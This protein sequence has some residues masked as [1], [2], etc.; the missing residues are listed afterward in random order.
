MDLLQNPFH[1]LNASPRDNRRRIMELADERSLLL[2]SSECMEARSELTN[3]RKR[4]SAEVAWLPGIGPKRVGEVL[5]LLESS[6]ADLLAVDNLSSIARANLLA[7]GL[8]RLSDHN[9]DDVAE[10]ILEISW[11]FEDLDADELSVIINEERVV[12]GFPEVSDLSAVEAEIQERRRHYRQ[13]IKSAL[14]NLSPKELVE[15]VTVAVESATDYGEEHGP[16]LIADLVDSYEVEAQ[17]FLDKEEGNIKALVEKLRAAVDAE[18]SDSTLAPMVNQLIQVVKNWDTVAQPIQVSAKSRGLDHDASHRVAGLVRGL[19][20]HMFNEHGKLDF[21]Q[22]LT[23]MLQEVFAEVGEVAERTAED[24]DALAE[25]AEEQLRYVEGLVNKAEEWRREITYE[26]E[27]GA[28][29][30]D[31]L[32]IS[33]EGI[34]WK[35]RRWDLDS[36]TRVRWGGTKHS[37]NGIPTGTTYSIVFGNS[38]NYTSIEL[39]KEA[40]YSNFI[41]RLWKA[42]GVRLLTEYLQGLREGKKYR[43]GSTIMSDHGMELERKKLFGS[44]E[45]IFC[46]WSELVVWNGAG[47]FCIGKKD[48]KKLAAAFSY[49]EEDNI[50]VLE[51][52]IRMFWKQGGD[53]LSSLLGE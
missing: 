44:N 32:R 24:A 19:A 40:T 6:P 36:I 18:R 10:W 29:F 38:S 20:I 23:N 35:G 12:S 26:A 42:V 37:V 8:A 46:R 48:D 13:V 15:A 28:I 45:R 34:E 33:P 16:I 30:K 43:F 7:A 25:I 52:V 1:I 21:S 27:V 14:D 4:L 51:A 49:Q 53:R 39:K 22:Q 3:P 17:G 9:A 47:V 41:D 11:A 50:H 31:K 5:S 2:D